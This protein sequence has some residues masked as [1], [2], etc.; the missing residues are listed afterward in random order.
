MFTVGVV[1][2]IQNFSVQNSLQGEGKCRFFKWQDELDS[3]QQPLQQQSQPAVPVA[4]PP[5][6]DRPA[7]TPQGIPTAAAGGS[8]VFAD[9]G[10]LPG[11]FTA[12]SP[13]LVA[14]SI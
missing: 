8:G 10:G 7:S 2:P 14:Y 9:E 3:N 5:G 6:N 4:G 11:I 13:M 1:S 12:F